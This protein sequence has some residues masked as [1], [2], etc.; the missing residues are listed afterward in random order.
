MSSCRRDFEGAFHL[1]LSLDLLQ[2]LVILSMRLEPLFWVKATLLNL[3]AALKIAHQFLQPCNWNPL[4]VRDDGRLSFVFLGQ[5]KAAQSLGFRLN[6]HGQHSCDGLD[7]S[8][9]RKLPHHHVLRQRF[10]RQQSRRPQQGNC[11][12]EVKPGADL[13]QGCRS[14]VDHDFADRQAEAGVGQRREDAVPAFPDGAIGQSDDG[15]LAQPK[16]E[17]HLHVNAVS[18]HT[19]DGG[20]MGFGDHCIDK[21]IDVS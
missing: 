12:G 1:L 6:G 9:Q 17:V 5:H 16:R 3:N 15:E 4:H 8:V 14:E 19:E 13:A 21:K 10:R 18:V 11:D 2:I 20:R 7:L